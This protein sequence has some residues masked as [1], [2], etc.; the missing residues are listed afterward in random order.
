[1]EKNINV[2]EF[3]PRPGNTKTRF[4]RCRN[5]KV[6]CGGPDIV[7]GMWALELGDEST[8]AMTPGRLTARQFDIKIDVLDRQKALY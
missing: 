5:G 8:V 4:V 2:Y 7:D 3:A 6:L 1:M